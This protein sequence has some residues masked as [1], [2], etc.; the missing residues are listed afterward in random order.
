MAFDLEAALKPVIE[1]GGSDL[2]LKVPSPPLI[3]IH[4]KLM[5]IPGADKLMPNDTEAVFQQIVTDDGKRDEFQ[6]ERELDFSFGMQ[7]AGRFRVQPVHPRGSI[8][9]VFGAIP[10][11]IKTV[12]ELNLPGAINDLADEE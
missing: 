6:L 5:P 1:T 11:D 7:G 8:S 2:H 10:S 3:R 4:G 9:F 12:E